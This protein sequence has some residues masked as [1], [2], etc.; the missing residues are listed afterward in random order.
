MTPLAHQLVKELCRPVN[1]RPPYIRS[2]SDVIRRKI[3]DIHCFDITDV[4]P[5]AD[6]ISKMT[7]H[8]QSPEQLEE[9]VSRFG[10]LPAPKTWIEYKLY[11][12]PYRV[13]LL[14]Q[15]QSD[16]WSSVDLILGLP[17][18]D[19]RAGYIGKISNSSSDFVTTGE[20]D[21]VPA[22]IPM[23]PELH[24]K[25]DGWK[26][27]EANLANCH[28]FLPL[29]NSP[30]IVGRINHV[31]HKG[32]Q[33]ET[34]NAFGK[35]FFPLNGWTEIKLKISKPPEIDDGEPHVS[36]ITGTRALHFCRKH[37]RIRRGRLEYVRAHWRGDASLGMSQSRY[38][39]TP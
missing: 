38:T 22:V 29:I 9:M 31:A 14:L 28:I 16:G 39:V 37:I 34:R 20:K 35:G 13:A 33:K 2:N 24:G 12:W 23:P 15:E 21:G 36:F 26:W 27:V 17:D 8:D 10:F 6:E 3:F 5:L 7:R 32:L 25:I 11:A 18:R 19:I 1:A 4:L 30:K